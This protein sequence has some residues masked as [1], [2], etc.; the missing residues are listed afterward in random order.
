MSE[1]L[2]VSTENG[3]WKE[4]V[5]DWDEQCQSFSESLDDYATASIPVLGALAGEPQRK[6]A[7]VY[8]IR[9]E[10]GF[11][12]VCQLNSTLLPKYNGM[13]LRVRHI[14]HA[15]RFDFEDNLTVDEY[16]TVLAELL[17]GVYTVSNSEM[18]APHIKFHFKSP[19][20][21][22]YFDQLKN[23]MQEK[24]TFSSIQLQGSWLY[25]TK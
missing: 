3:L 23:V 21:R 1:F 7:G 25:I 9:D 5:N 14:V 20:E 6:Y 10:N 11:A 18:Q 12:G 15:P 17:V 22:T 16:S 8:A 24:T 4:L 13:V 2:R 19:A